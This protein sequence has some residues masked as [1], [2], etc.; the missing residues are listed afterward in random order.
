MIYKRKFYTIFIFKMAYEY[1]F[2][3]ETVTWL[4]G[5]LSGGLEITNLPEI[6]I[7]ETSEYTNIGYHN[8][9]KLYRALKPNDKILNNTL[10]SSFMPTSWTLSLEVA[11]KFKHEN[12]PIIEIEITNANVLINTTELDVD[13]IV[14]KLGGFPE[15]AEVILLPG[16]YRFEVV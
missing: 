15:E 16:Y 5:W 11:E 13:Y 4:G 1:E 7:K 10:I 8:K 6:V 14:K 3:E 2:S 12:L 9:T